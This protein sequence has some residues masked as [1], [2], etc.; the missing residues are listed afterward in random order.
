MN[1]NRTEDISFD[2]VQIQDYDEDISTENVLNDKKVTRDNT[3]GMIDDYDFDGIQVTTLKEQDVPED[4]K[5]KRKGYTKKLEY[6]ENKRKRKD[7][8]PRKNYN[9]NDQYKQNKP[10]NDAAEFNF[11]MPERNQGLRKMRIGRMENKTN[12]SNF[13]EDVH[14]E[15]V[16]GGIEEAIK[17]FNNDNSTTVDTSTFETTTLDDGSSFFDS[18][19]NFDLFNIGN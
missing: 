4:L 14:K 12:H 2:S 19:Y 10:N 11:D 9:R 7:K 3:F 1:S 16:D 6:Y 15:N 17:Q 5:R 18:E 13:N 8:G